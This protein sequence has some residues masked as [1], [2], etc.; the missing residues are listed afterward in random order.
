[1]LVVGD[2]NERRARARSD[3]DIRP[4]VFAFTPT[5]EPGPCVEARKTSRLF[6]YEFSRFCV[7][8][9]Y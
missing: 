5:A 8:L 9:Y 1:M 2:G 4:G 3:G 7:S 6:V